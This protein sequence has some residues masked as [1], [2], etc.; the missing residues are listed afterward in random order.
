MSAAAKAK[1]LLGIEN[2]LLDI[3]VNVTDEFL[4]KHGQRV[5]TQSLAKEEDRPLF[6]EISKF[7]DVQ[8]I[9]GGACQNSIRGA[10]WMSPTPGITHFIGSIGKDENGKKLTEA[11]TKDGVHVHYYLSEKC[12]T[13]TC[14]VL[15]NQKERGLVADLAAAN[16]YQHSH[17]ESAEIQGLLPKVDM[18]Y[19]TGYFLTVSPKTMIE[20]GEHCAKHNKLFVFCI[21]AP[22]V[23]QF[24]WEDFQ[25]V[26]AYADVVICNGEEAVA[27]LHKA[28]IEHS[29]LKDG[30]KKAAALPKANA[31]RKRTI[32]FTQGSQPAVTYHDDKIE[33]WPVLPA[34]AEEIVDTNGAGDAFSGGLL[35]GLAQEKPFSECIRAAM[36]AAH[37]ILHVSGTQYPPKCDFDWK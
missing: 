29:D 7:S 23:V 9:A 17:F 6:E 20:L 2:P 36:F 18:V 4:Q 30:A 34:K 3:S 1:V 21:A 24:Y 28:G 14:A 32:I 27:F 31:Q 13:G 35:A 26:Y 8:Y 5:G 25:K 15:I 33:E 10:Q 16:D 12:R 19:T 11:A 37:K 22:F